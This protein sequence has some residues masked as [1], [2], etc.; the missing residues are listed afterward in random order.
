M[1]PSL[2][3]LKRSRTPVPAHPLAA[4]DAHQPHPRLPV[5]EPSHSVTFFFLE[6][7]TPHPRRE[8]GFK[9]R[10]KILS[11]TRKQFLLLNQ[12]FKKID[13]YIP[14]QSLLNNDEFLRTG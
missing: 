6:G 5:R 13:Q 4:S 11:R 14:K 8:W 12:F 2:L 1:T 3:G 9:D 10:R 7:G